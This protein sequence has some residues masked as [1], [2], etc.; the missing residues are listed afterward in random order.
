MSLQPFETAEAHGAPSVRQIST[1]LD[2]R[3]GELLRLTRAFEGTSVHILSLTIISTI[4]CAIVRLLV[5]NVDDAE[6]ILRDTGFPVSI[7]EL[8]VVEM[9]QGRKGLLTICSA[10]LAGEVNIHYAYPLLSRPNSRP[11]LALLVDN[12]DAASAILRKKDFV[13]LDEGDL[14]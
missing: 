11:A 8:V 13:V 3:C 12:M 2:N 1:F 9:P 4:D 5:D 7:A 6:R 10:L 14:E